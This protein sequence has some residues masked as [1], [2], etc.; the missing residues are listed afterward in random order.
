MPFHTWPN[1]ATVQSP[2]AAAAFESKENATWTTESEDDNTSDGNNDRGA[3]PCDS[4]LSWRTDDDAL[5]PCYLPGEENE[6]DPA[7]EEATKI[8][9]QAPSME[10]TQDAVQMFM[11]PVMQPML[12]L[13]ADM[14]WI[15]VPMTPWPLAPDVNT[16]SQSPYQDVAGSSKGKTT[17]MW[18]NLPNNYTRD[19]LLGLINSEG[20]AGSYDFF[21]SPMDFTSSALVGYAFI[22]FVNG[23]VAE[24]FFQHFQGFKQWSLMSVKVSEVGWSTLQG[25]D[26]HIERYRNSPVMHPDVP[27]E[28]RPLLLQSGQSVPFPPPTKKLRAPHLKDCRGRA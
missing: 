15:Q 13:A 27:D 8:E 1:T 4:F 25:L 22:N 3:N 5:Y 19:D 14:P 11:V 24:Q 12:F 17:V 6:E 20:F 9:K 18:R 28:M 23:Q 10:P 21:Y 16:V 7:T 2:G 26:G